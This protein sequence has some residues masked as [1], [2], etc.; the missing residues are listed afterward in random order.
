MGGRAS[1]YEDEIMDFFLSKTMLF[2]E[3]WFY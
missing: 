1:K 3:R 2:G